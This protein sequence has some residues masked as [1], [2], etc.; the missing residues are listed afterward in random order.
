MAKVYETLI[1]RGLKTLSE[2]PADLQDKVKQ[3]LI[4]DGYSELT[5]EA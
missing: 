2:V 3:L 5:E 1:I 4:N